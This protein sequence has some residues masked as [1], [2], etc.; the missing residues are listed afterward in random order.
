MAGGKP[1]RGRCTTSGNHGEVSGDGVLL[2]DMA[3]ADAGGNRH[4]LGLEEQFERRKGTSALGEAAGAGRAVG[5][6]DC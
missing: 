1:C 2:A 5:S 4:G 3:R 6:S